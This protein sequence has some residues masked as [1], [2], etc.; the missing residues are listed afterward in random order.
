MTH[1]TFKTFIYVISL[2]HSGRSGTG[3]QCIGKFV[4]VVLIKSIGKEGKRGRRCIRRLLPG[5]K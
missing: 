4:W 3:K 2:N 1:Q 5:T